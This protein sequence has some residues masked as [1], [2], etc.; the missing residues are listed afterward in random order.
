MS[1]KICRQCNTLKPLEQFYTHT[2]MADGHLNKC[3]ECVKA[4]VRKFGASR[5]AEQRGAGRAYDRE[6]QRRPKYRALN[7]AWRAAHPVEVAAI[8]QRWAEKNYEKCKA[9]WTLSNAVR[10]GKVIKGTTCT[11]CGATTELEAHHEDYSKPLAVE[12]LCLP[13]H[14]ETRHKEPSATE[15]CTSERFPESS[16]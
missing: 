1:E 7:E 10:D 2:Q 14:G 13:C 9:E 11:R 16:S 15:S 3:I 12:W 4:R 5:T 6:K 8:K